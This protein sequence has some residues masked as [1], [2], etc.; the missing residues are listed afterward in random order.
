MKILCVLILCFCL[1]CSTISTEGGRAVFVGNVIYA[2]ADDLQKCN[3]SKIVAASDDGEKDNGK[4]NAELV[5]VE[6]TD[7]CYIG[8]GITDNLKALGV[9]II[10]FLFGVGL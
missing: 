9:S 10:S 3:I 6:G 4:A 2:A 1:G 5:L 8:S 7:F